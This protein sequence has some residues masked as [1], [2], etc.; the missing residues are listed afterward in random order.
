MKLVRYTAPNQ[1]FALQQIATPQDQY[2][3]IR[4]SVQSLQDVDNSI[5]E[6][7]FSD[8]AEGS[9]IDVSG[10]PKAEGWSVQ[11]QGFFMARDDVTEIRRNDK[12][13]LIRRRI[14]AVVDVWTSDNPSASFRAT[15]SDFVVTDI[16]T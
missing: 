2:V 10:I 6:V 8:D 16:E 5:I 13:I 11:S 14:S 7:L 3:R 12:Y 1:T 4:A 15:E 9:P